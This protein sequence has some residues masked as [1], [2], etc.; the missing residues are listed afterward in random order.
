VKVLTAAEMREVDR[1]TM[2]YG[3]S[4]PVLMENAGCRAVEFLVRRF[5]PLSRE[6]VVVLCGKGNNGG[7]GYVIARQL[8]TRYR[9]ARLDV[10][11]GFDED[12]EPRR[13]LEACGCGVATEIA[14][15]MRHATIVV[16]AVLGTGVAGAARGRA[17]ELIREINAGFPRA[18]V[19][20]VDVPSGMN[21]DS[22]E[23]EGE[24]ARADA[25]I[26]FTAPKLCH[27][28][29]P[30]C[31]RMGEWAVGH[32]GSAVPLMDGVKAHLAEPADFRDLL[33]PRERDANKGR[34]GHVLVVGG[35][36]GKT[37]A[38]EMAGLSALRA[39]A[40]L[41]T[42]ASTA[43][44]LGTLELMT[45]PMPRAWEEVGERMNVVALGP[46]L[47]AEA[48]A[49]EMARR[50]VADASQMVVVDADGLNALAGFEWRANAVRVL[51]PHPGEMSRLTGKTVAEVQS[52]RLGVARA[53]AAEQ[54]CIL[55]LKG[56]RTVIA[57]PDGRAWINPTG[58]PALAKGG[59]GDVL[60]GL[61]AGFLAQ[62][63]DHAER[64]VIAAVY[65]HGLAGQLGA[66]VRGEHTLLAAE[67]LD[68]LPEAIRVCQDVPDEL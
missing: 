11:A 55:V 8:F 38:A 51:T 46:G 59:T 29:A 10:V 15:E 4:G 1:R 2:E 3:I 14:P 40:G 47:G 36:A 20:A 28:L 23:S 57:M 53:Y 17:L 7:D 9:M 30:N 50:C 44:R 64:A 19:F 41:V 42:V 48:A 32:I 16:D 35:A 13:M 39:G 65:L 22:G 67:I 26:T 60:A 24:V 54:K 45:A 21:T 68:Y 6:H 34:Y 25:T 43:Q 33:G 5:G 27:V 56:Y 12:C 63:A 66:R 31:D 58:T 18:R 52:D 61:I 62:F 49:V 37:G